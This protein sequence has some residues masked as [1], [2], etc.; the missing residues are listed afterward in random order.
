MEQLNNPPSEYSYTDPDIIIGVNLKEDFV[1]HYKQTQFKQTKEGFAAAVEKI[2][3]TVQG[4]IADAYGRLR[5]AG[6]YASGIDK[7]D[8]IV[9][10]RATI[11]PVLD[12]SPMPDV[13]EQRKRIRE[14]V[15]PMIG[16]MPECEPWDYSET[17]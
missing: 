12:C 4:M 1:K 5:D 15:N 13:N 2:P 9:W 17:D 3:E 6:W 16:A 8:K 14:S 10:R 11:N 7:F